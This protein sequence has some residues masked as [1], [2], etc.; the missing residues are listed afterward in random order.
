MGMGDPLCNGRADP[1]T[2]PVTS[3]ESAKPLLRV[4][5]AVRQT[6]DTVKGDSVS[7]AR[8]H[9]LDFELVLRPSRWARGMQVVG[10]IPEHIVAQLG[11]LTSCRSVWLH[12][13]SVSHICGRHEATPRDAEFVLEYM[14]AAVM[15]PMFCG[16]E[17]RG[18]AT[19]IALVDF[20]A[21]ERRYLYLSI[22]LARGSAGDD[23]MWVGGGY[24]MREHTLRRYLRAKRLQA[25]TGR[26]L[27][28]GKTRTA[29]R[30]PSG[31]ATQ[32]P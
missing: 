17:W 10:A 5:L 13:E 18:D 9:S 6:G 7:A 2:S 29:R 26:K 23:E 12:E 4:V 16:L 21:A 27:E 32:M 11:L 3:A 31:V 1:P 22:K 15:H 14:P 8:P 20:I 30:I 25:V 24:P 19:R 28:G